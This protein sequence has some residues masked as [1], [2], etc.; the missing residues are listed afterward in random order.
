MIKNLGMNHVYAVFIS[1]TVKLLFSNLKCDSIL[2]ELHQ[3]SRSL[4]YFS[5]PFLLLFRIQGKESPLL[6][7][8]NKKVLLLLNCFQLLPCLLTTLLLHIQIPKGIGCLNGLLP[9]LCLSTKP[10]A[11]ACK[12][13]LRSTET[14]IIS[15]YHQHSYLCA[16]SSSVQEL[17][18]NNPKSFYIHRKSYRL[19]TIRHHTSRPASMVLTR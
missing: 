14:S 8:S 10:N 17:H 5:I 9:Q 12:L 3:S 18:W 16:S 15:F 4:I 2:T 13:T 11:G 7:K 1:L 19:M 6:S